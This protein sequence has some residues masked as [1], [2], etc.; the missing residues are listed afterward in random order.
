MKAITRRD[1]LHKRRW[2]NGFW[3]AIRT[4][5]NNPY[6]SYWKFYEKRRGWKA[7]AVVETDII[8]VFDVMDAEVWCDKNLGFNHYFRGWANDD[9]LWA[10]QYNDDAVKFK[11]VWG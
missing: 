3:V 5:F 9:C 7:K 4:W 6:I 11:L 8:D 2:E 1:Y 10:F